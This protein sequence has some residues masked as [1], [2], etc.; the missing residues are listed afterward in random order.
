MWI[1]AILMTQTHWLVATGQSAMICLVIF[2]NFYKISNF[3]I[4]EQK[5]TLDIKKGV[6]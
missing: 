4:W 3:V 1:M 6:L 5:M 2:M